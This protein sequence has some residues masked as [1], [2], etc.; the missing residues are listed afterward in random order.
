MCVLKSRMCVLKTRMWVFENPNT[1]FDLCRKCVSWMCV[2]ET[3]IRVLSK[4]QIRVFNV[5]RIRVFK[6]RIRVIEFSNPRFY[7]NPNVGFQKTQIRVLLKPKYGRMVTNLCFPNSGFYL[8]K[9]VFWKPK[10][11]FWK[12]RIRVFKSQIRVGP[13]YGFWNPKTPYWCTWIGVRGEETDLCLRLH[14]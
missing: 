4:T 12:T 10:Y 8:S 11:G 9:C 13:K 3:Q 14:Y 1:G 7:S 2:L 5:I 6:T